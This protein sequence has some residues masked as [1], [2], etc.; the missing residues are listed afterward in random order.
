[1]IIVVQS[2]KY[3]PA[4]KIPKTKWASSNVRGTICPLVKIG[5]TDLLKPGWAIARPAHPSPTSLILLNLELQKLC[6]YRKIF[7][8]L[9]NGLK[10]ITL[11]TLY[12]LYGV[13]NRS[14]FSPLISEW[15]SQFQITV[16][17]LRSGKNVRWA[18]YILCCFP[19]LHRFLGGETPCL[20]TIGWNEILLTKLFWATV[21]KNCSSDW[22]KLL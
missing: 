15:I 9:D 11:F 14:W 7:G 17:L 19:T 21:R 6:Q 22:E 18:N 2:I 3:F 16:G 20:C 12:R 13:H 5:W 1:M 4:R 8:H 10:K